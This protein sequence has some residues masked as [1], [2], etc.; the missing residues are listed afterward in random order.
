MNKS[1]NQADQAGF[2]HNLHGDWG[3]WGGAR[4]T[5]RDQICVYLYV[6]SF[7]LYL[8]SHRCIQAFCHLPRDCSSSETLQ[9]T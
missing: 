9:S 4:T 6:L 5:G 3:F 1:F 2:F 7:C 8:F